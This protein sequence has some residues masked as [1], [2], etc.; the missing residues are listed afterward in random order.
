VVT[1]R[2]IILGSGRILYTN[3]IKQQRNGA[4]LVRNLPVKDYQNG[5]G[6]ILSKHEVKKVKLSLSVTN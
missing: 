6:K 1:L 3:E 2:Q 4:F 5:D